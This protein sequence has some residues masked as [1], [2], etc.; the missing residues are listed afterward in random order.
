MW[1]RA[2]AFLVG[3][4]VAASSAA[5]TH[6]KF[7]A[8]LGE[9]TAEVAPD[10][11]VVAIE[12]AS[13]KPTAG[14][15]S[16]TQAAVLASVLGALKGYGVTGQDIET[17]G[18]SVALA[19]GAEVKQ[20]RVSLRVRSVLYVRLRD[21]GKLTGLF[22]A[23]ES[24]GGTILGCHYDVSD[25]EAREDDLRQAALENAHHRA[26]LYAKVAGV[27][28]GGLDI[29][30]EQGASA[31]ANNDAAAPSTIGQWGADSASIDAG[32]V[33]LQAVVYAAFAVEP[34]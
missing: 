11:V 15:A 7:I 17:L 32:A 20:G 10:Y 31:V 34:P 30:I 12:A 29:V 14:E 19:R 4:A 9:A 18:P 2:A 8:A 25:R 22:R 24:V 1:I 13:E 3:L 21:F 33:Q 23:A 26:E 5:E 28:L 16:A 6:P 27:K